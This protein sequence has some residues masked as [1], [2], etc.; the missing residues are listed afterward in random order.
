MGQHRIEGAMD[1]V[2]RP[3]MVAG[4]GEQRIGRHAGAGAAKP[5]AGRRQIPQI[6]E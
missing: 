3:R 4:E 5:D 2:A 1:R 6:C